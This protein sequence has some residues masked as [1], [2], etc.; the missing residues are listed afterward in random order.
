MA[1]VRTMTAADV[2]PAT[3]M[4]LRGDWG[5]RR[6]FLEFATSHPE[7]MPV[8]ALDGSEIVGTGIGTANGPVGWIGAI[9]VDT[10][11]R[12]RG[13]GRHLT[14]AVIARLEAAGCRTFALV[15]SGEG[16]PLY[17]GMGFELQTAYATL[18]A[19]GTAGAASLDVAVRTFQP[20]DL[21][22]MAALDRQ[23][24]GEERGHLI[25]RFATETSARVLV[26]AAGTIDAF[27]VRAP[28]GGGATIA[29][30]MNDGVRIL[31]ARRAAVG[32]ERQVRAGLPLENRAGIARLRSLGW[33]RS[34]NAP[35]MIRGEPIGWHPDLI[36][37]QFAMA[38]G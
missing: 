2:E 36:W 3:A 29:R 9:F 37:G 17:Q 21:E 4:I 10:S 14:E 12:R 18:E 30:T 32:P 8:V 20:A 23:A 27:T 38:L 7:C 25:A 31:E 26:G 28:W 33:T 11:V 15:A 1:D 5:D 6:I 35:R 16:R 24:T 19:P 34:W 13:I 22:A